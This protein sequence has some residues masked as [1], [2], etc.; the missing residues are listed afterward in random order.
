MKFHSAF[1]VL[2][3]IFSLKLKTNAKSSSETRSKR[4]PTAA[5]QISARVAKSTEVRR[6]CNHSTRVCVMSRTF[7]HSTVAK[8]SKSQV[9]V[10]EQLIA[11]RTFNILAG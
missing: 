1:D 5:V 10:G 3:D 9:A 2:L 8:H 4:Q 11:V 6:D 7:S